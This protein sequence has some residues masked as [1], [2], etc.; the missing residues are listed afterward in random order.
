M[1]EL[2]Y[3]LNTERPSRKLCVEAKDRIEFMEDV[4]IEIQRICLGLG[5]TEYANVLAAT[6]HG[7]R[8]RDVSHT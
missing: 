8:G 1:S 4:L 7:L 5:S 6:E 3:R 2:T